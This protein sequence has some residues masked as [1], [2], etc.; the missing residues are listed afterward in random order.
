VKR[1]PENLNDEEIKALLAQP[2]KRATT[3]LRD[4][5]MLRLMFNTVLRSSD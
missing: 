5:A 2:N 3:G 4:L 1:I